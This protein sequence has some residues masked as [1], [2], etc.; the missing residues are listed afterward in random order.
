MCRTRRDLDGIG[1]EPAHDVPVA[2]R[3]GHDV[4]EQSGWERR[5]GVDHRVRRVDDIDRNG[6]RRSQERGDLPGLGGRDREH[7]GHDLVGH[8]AGV[9]ERGRGRSEHHGCR[10]EK[11]GP[12]PLHATRSLA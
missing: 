11:R 3:C 6:A 5:D 1:H 9:C 8:S 2:D 4:V 10:E 7:G 12:S